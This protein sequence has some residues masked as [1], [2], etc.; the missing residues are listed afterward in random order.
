MASFKYC[1]CHYEY[2][3]SCSFKSFACCKPSRHKKSFH[4]RLLI[5]ETWT[6]HVETSIQGSDAAWSSGCPITAGLSTREV[7]EIMHHRA[8]TH[9]SRPYGQNLC[10]DTGTLPHASSLI[11]L[12]SCPVHRLY[13]KMVRDW[14]VPTENSNRQLT[15]KATGAQDKF[16]ACTGCHKQHCQARQMEVWE[17][18]RSQSYKQ[19]LRR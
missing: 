3:I 8:A 16:P 4:P 2:A 10:S 17:Q 19:H 18:G 14:W 15:G 7:R 13:P 6:Y 9:P 12:F 5:S 11:D 1:I